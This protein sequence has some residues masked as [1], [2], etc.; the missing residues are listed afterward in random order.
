[1]TALSGSQF[2]PPALPEVDDFSF[3]SGVGV[4]RWL[5]RDKDKLVR[6]LNDALT[7]KLELYSYQLHR[8]HYYTKKTD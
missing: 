4:K 1:M 5:N 8:I 6:M 7:D 2:K 3:V